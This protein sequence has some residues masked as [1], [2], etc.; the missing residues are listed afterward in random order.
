ML[1]ASWERTAVIRRVKSLIVRIVVGR[2]GRVGQPTHRL[3]SAKSLFDQ[4]R[5][6]SETWV[7]I[8]ASAAKERNDDRSWGL[9]K[10][11]FE[12]IL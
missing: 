8:F 9:T 5:G 2:K 10:C 11:G 12:E 6:I 3:M 7:N 4:L 1:S